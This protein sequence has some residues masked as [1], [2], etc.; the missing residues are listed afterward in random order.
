MHKKT[1]TQ[2]QK[3]G[4]RMTAQII[5]LLSLTVTFECGTPPIEEQEVM[6]LQRR[7]SQV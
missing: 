1:T 6:P 7:I 3:T 4:H 5:N 2:R